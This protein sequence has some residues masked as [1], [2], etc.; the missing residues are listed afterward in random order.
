[1]IGCAVCGCPLDL[2]Q[3]QVGSC[4][5]C[6]CSRAFDPRDMDPL[7]VLELTMAR[8]EIDRSWS[9]RVKHGLVA[10]SVDAPA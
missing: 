7:L 4:A 9:L 10:E 6:P 2:H 8:E 5:A 1:M 3:G